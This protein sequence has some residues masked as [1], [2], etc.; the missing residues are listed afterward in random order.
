MR[1]PR[2]EQITPGCRPPIPLS[3][4]PNPF[5]P[6]H[7]RLKRAGVEAAVDVYPG[8][9]HAFDMLLPFLKVSK[10]A[11]AAFEKRFEYAVRHYFAGQHSHCPPKLNNTDS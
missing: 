4:Q 2:E 1:L 9:F 6:K 8:L 10:K 11:A 7:D 5:T 3:A